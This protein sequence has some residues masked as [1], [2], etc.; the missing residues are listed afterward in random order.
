MTRPHRHIHRA[1][2]PLALC[3][4]LGLACTETA[5]PAAAADT[6]TDTVAEVSDT[7]FDPSDLFKPIEICETECKTCLCDCGGTYIDTEAGG[8][9]DVCKGSE[10]TCPICPTW[11][12]DQQDASVVDS[13]Q[14]DVGTVDAGTPDAGATYPCQPKCDAIGSKSEGWYDGCTNELLN[15]P[16][17]SGKLWAQCAKCDSFCDKKGTK[18]EGWY[19]SCSK[20]LIKWAQCSG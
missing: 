18:S 2:A 1:L 12:E 17:G 7:P 11:C 15:K 10:P 4:L 14:S 3:A 16:I 13:E 19:D 8:C 20:S 6:D 5:P 9:W